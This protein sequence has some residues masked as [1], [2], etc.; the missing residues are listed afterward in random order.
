MFCKAVE[1]PHMHVRLRE[2]VADYLLESPQNHQHRGKRLLIVV[3]QC[4]HQML[5]QE[6]TRFVTFVFRIVIKQLLEAS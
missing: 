3:I 5:L 6:K 2:V 1:C 4:S